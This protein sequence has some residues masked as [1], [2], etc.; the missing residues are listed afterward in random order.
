M[1]QTA[2][3]MTRAEWVAQANDEHALARYDAEMADALADLT[4]LFEG[5]T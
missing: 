1:T 4:P 2:G 3:E 5:G